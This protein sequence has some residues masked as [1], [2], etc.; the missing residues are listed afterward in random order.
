MFVLG[1][2]HTYPQIRFLYGFVVVV[3]VVALPSDC[4]TVYSQLV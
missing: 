2:P 1:L 4:L 3:V